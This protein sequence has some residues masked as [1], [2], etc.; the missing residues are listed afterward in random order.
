MS[1]DVI[2]EIKK[3]YIHHLGKQHKRIDGRNFDEIRPIEIEKDMIGTAEG[4]ARVKLGDTVVM[5]GAK[6]GVGEPYP[7]A[8]KEGVLTTSVEL[9]PLAG[10]EFDAGPTREAAI[11]LAR[12][13]DR[14]IR[15][16]KAIDLEKLC[17]VEGEKVWVVYIDINVL[18]YDG[19]LYDAST[20]GALL[21]LTT[22]KVP[23]STLGDGTE[24]FALPVN[25]YP[26]ACTAVKFGDIIVLDPTLDEENICD[27]RLTVTTDEN[28]DIRA[29]QK[30]KGGSFTIPEI[31]EVIK[32]SQQTGKNV[33]ENVINQV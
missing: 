25:H 18:D 11:E 26:I 31:K 6:L 19:N 33:R 27:A 22:T 15:E 17:I 30:G 7:D 5:V 12:V 16:S 13:T 24:D 8:A 23:A 32:L 10:P 21:A 29:M 1:K 4:S 28:G 3:D 20:L 2:S 9:N 14:G